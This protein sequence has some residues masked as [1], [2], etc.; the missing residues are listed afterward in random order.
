MPGT[1]TTILIDGTPTDG[2]DPWIDSL[3]A[4]GTWTDSNGGTVT[5]QWT[6]FQGTMDGQNSYSWTPLAL[7]GLR[8]ALSL[9]E[10]VANIDFVEVS[11]AANADVKF[12]WGTEAQAGGADVLGWSDL[13]GFEDHYENP[14]SE[15]RDL[16]FNAQASSAAGAL[17]K[18]GLGLVTMV[19][20]I[21]HLLGLAHPHD[22]GAGSDATTFPGVYH[23][24]PSY[25]YGDGDLNQGVYTTMSY[26][27]GW[28][29]AYAGE[30]DEAFGLQYGP[31]A[32]DIAAIQA[33]YGVNTSYATGNNLYTLPKVSAVGSYFSAIW[34]TGGVDTISN[35]GASYKTVI[36][37]R[38]ATAGIHGGG[39]ISYG[40]DMYG[41]IVSGGYTI[42]RGVVIENAIGGNGDDT[43]TGNGAV[44]RL[45]G[46][47]G[48]D[49]LEG[50]AG[51]D[52]MIGGSGSD[53]YYV[54]DYG[55]VIVDSDDP[56]IDIVYSSLADY[57]LAATLENLTL[58]GIGPSNGT[59]NG[60]GN[61]ITGTA[62]NNTLVGGGG[63]DML[64]GLAGNDRLVVKDFRYTWADGGDGVDTLVLDGAGLALYLP[65]PSAVLKFLNIERID[66][67]G[68][69]DNTIWV[70][71]AT[72]VNNLGQWS[73]GQRI[74]VVERDL[75]D[76]VQFT[77]S[78]WTKSGTV[79]NDA[80]TFD[81]WVFGNAEVHIEQVETIPPPPSTILLSS[82]NGSTGFRLAGVAID[83]YS[84]HSVAS[85]GDVN[86]DGFDDVIVG[87]I[88]A[89]AGPA[90]PGASYVVFGKATSFAASIN[91]ATLDGNTGFKLSGVGVSDASGHSVASAG[92]VNGDGFADLII[93]ARWA[94]PHGS[95]SGASYLVFGKASG[96]AADINLNTL[97]GG[98][99]F[100]LSGAAAS[101]SSGYSVASAGDFNGDG[102]DDLIVGAVGA[103][104]LDDSGASYIIYGKASGFA[105]TLEL[106]GLTAAAGVKLNG[107]AA[108]EGSGNSVASA[109]DVNGDGFDD[110]IVGAPGAGTSVGYRYAGASYIV[111]GR[112]A[113]TAS[114]EMS[115]LNG[116]NGFRLSGVPGDS[117]GRSVASAGD[118]NGD[119][120]ADLIVGAPYA[121]SHGTDSGLSY[122]VFGKASGFAASIDLSSLNGSNGFKLSGPAT[123]AKSGF[124]VASAGD[125]NGDG[126]ADLIVGAKGAYST[127]FD[128]GASYVVFGK[129]SGFAANVDLSTLDGSNGFALWGEAAN[130][131]SGLSVASA[132]DVNGDGYD[133]LII[134]ASSADPNGSGSGASYVVFGGA[135]GGSTTRVTTTGTAAAEILIG[136]RG[137]DVLIGGGGGDV[138]HAGAGNDRL[139]VKDL[140]F[141]LADGG[142]GTD[143]LV[144]G[145]AGLSLDLSNPLVAAKLEGI[146]RIDLAG[147]GN[148]LIINQL[149][150]LGGVGAV[151]DGRHVLV[152][153]RNL[154]DEVQF[155]EPGWTKA[156]SVLAAEGTFD[157]WVLGNAEVHVEQDSGVNIVGTAGDD[158][159]STSVTVPG[160]FLATAL[161]DIIDGRAGADTMA[162]G[163]G[164][165]TYVVDNT[166]DVVLEAVNA[167]QDV[168]NSTVSYALQANIEE[169]W[170]M[171]G[172]AINGTGNDLDNTL[173]GNSNNNILDGGAGAD[174]MMGWGGNDTYIVDSTADFVL[175]NP[176]QGIDTVMASVT[177]WL[178]AYFENL[179]LTGTANIGSTGNE[180]ANLL[181]GNAGK[182]VLDG[183]A[184][185]DTMAGG[186]GDDTYVVDV[187]GDVVTEAAD[188]GTDTVEA[189]VGWTLGGN[190]E[191]LKL[192]GLAHLNGTGNG[193]DNA[194]FGNAGANVLNGGAGADTMSGGGGDDTY[195]VDTVGDVVVELAGG[196]TDGVVAS[197]SW[198]LGANL[199]RLTLAGI[200]KFDGTG[201][202][203]N[204]WLT[205]NVNKNTLDGG[206]GADTMAGG[207]GNDTYVVD[208]AG[209][210]VIE[211]EG[212]GS[213]LVLASISHSLANEVERLLLTGTAHLNGTGNGLANVLYGNDGN[214]V[215][216]GKAGADSMT[217][218]L[219]DDTYIADDAGDVATE[220]AAGGADVVQS[221]VSWRLGAN[222]ERLVL[223]GLADINATGNGQ[224]NMLTGNAG[225][226]LLD[227]GADADTMAGG[228][229]D[230]T[231]VVD[232]ADDK[233]TEKA[234]EG[235][236]TVRS[237]IAHMLRG[238]VEKLV[239]TGNAAISGLGNADANVLVGNAAANLLDGRTGADTM[240]GGAGDDV[241]VVETAGDVVIE[242]ANGGNDEVQ[243]SISYTLTANVERLK[244]VAAG[245]LDVTG[246][247]L[248]NGLT[249]NGGNNVLDGGLGADAMAGGFGDDTYI[250]DHAG[251]RTFENG[252]AGSDTVLSSVNHALRANVENLV[253][254]GS[255]A[256]RGEGNAS[257]N[258]LTGN[259]AS[260]F[261]NGLA[262]S[263]TMA[264]GGGD[265]TYVV[266]MAGDMVVE[267]AN[268]GT[269]EVRSWVSYQLGAN[270]ERLQL[271]GTADIDGAGN[272]LVNMVAGNS[273]RNI[274]D[275]GLGSDLLL[276]GGGGDTFCFSTALGTSNVDRIQTFNHAS[277][278]I[279]LDQAIFAGLGL[280]GLAAGAFNLGAVATQADDRILFHSAAK[281]L[282]YDADGLGGGAAVKFATLDALTGILDHT[283]FL[284]V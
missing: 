216:D 116:N 16:L 85:A 105:A 28:P 96:F 78:G 97:S 132:G 129:A 266:D 33:I 111:F 222:F 274:L 209:D 86:G 188:Q 215:L 182:N 161:D 66:L 145:G 220:D 279:Q 207:Q 46:G 147:I 19:H 262:G 77:D 47:S 58:T 176:D 225:N 249:G 219:G 30:T 60:L 136:R 59:G 229:G 27:F 152:V 187:A 196:G 184:G 197:M 39:Y 281:S 248:D 240:E 166:G 275:G 35:E 174:Y 41:R 106:S 191:Q 2:S 137:N 55:D 201:N 80:G 123:W 218:G 158:I 130:D 267:L 18:G 156:G 214:N 121:D 208:A 181:T 254:T 234:G 273:G 253:L 94:Q 29:G 65:T 87:A 107:A 20:E 44:N 42:A 211:A 236:D 138:F 74:L 210:V 144:L 280:G 183:A 31:M 49:R 153:E 25:T 76:V 13:P 118:V 227:G 108:G 242:A 246:N 15:T 3:V 251:D 146:E 178:G 115:G 113:G 12:W 124:S 100:K 243:S 151:R 172:G 163:F 109:C 261:L 247:G 150:V 177:F 10:S 173:W 148:T 224:V 260:N 142:A 160:Q 159:I 162:A 54:D 93:G 141:R 252:T 235:F 38:E 1:A 205:G 143:T 259:G 263:D 98:N 82:L 125:F 99:G 112:P 43:I 140:A 228:L 117:S 189:W 131:K 45:E 50:G 223:T 81:R 237:S 88:G 157:R 17:V 110:V 89:D 264:G 5:I 83:D 212:E 120:Y 90:K 119:G 255:A 133:D 213:D 175:E 24:W 232:S 282:Y 221:S 204:N 64:N 250:V 7:A 199:E 230:D 9:W 202:G 62:G 241:Y 167:G 155:V 11:G 8:E 278:T 192:M 277:D 56:G 170:L 245:N 53:T 91:L 269:D 276:G 164:G 258:V 75:G 73:G 79:T 206:A 270:V 195:Y 135:F 22:G 203:L 179:A 26:N 284:I 52:T 67:T 190:L 271:H 194:L 127:G 101:D 134:G 69:G 265:D 84:G 165:D 217:G 103:G 23:E 40:T 34:D 185:A 272:E 226:N 231:Y 14:A 154:S 114:I 180:L 239:L 186:L 4:G 63:A 6:A 256:I 238:N 21:G 48:N 71:R 193:F 102:Y 126:L 244:L 168:V 72:V 171:G 37:L 139:T 104:A 36:D 233:V 61:T 92:D 257:S 32:L 268:G 122:V 198:T 128:A 70:D 200:G 57:A 169:L 51:A 95:A 68:T 149:S 283:D